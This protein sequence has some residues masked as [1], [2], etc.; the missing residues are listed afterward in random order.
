ML[1][2][3]LRLTPIPLPQPGQPE[4]QQPA[5]FGAALCGCHQVGRQ[6]VRA[7]HVSVAVFDGVCATDQK[8]LDSQERDITP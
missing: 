5:Q 1:V 2:R 8:P 3:R 6:R 7:F 4:G